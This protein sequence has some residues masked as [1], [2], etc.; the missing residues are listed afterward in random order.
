ML[1]QFVSERVLIPDSSCD[2]GSPLVFVNKKDDGIRMAVDYLEVNMQLESTENQFP[3]QPILF[4]RI[5]RARLIESIVDH[6]GSW[7]NRNAVKDVAALDTYS[8][9]HPELK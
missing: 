3:Y 5:G 1:D 9:E 8:Q 7:L 2:F 6:E 4:Q